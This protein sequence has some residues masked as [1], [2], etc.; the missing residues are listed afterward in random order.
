MAEGC[1][2]V[3]L[4]SATQTKDNAQALQKRT[5]KIPKVCENVLKWIYLDGAGHICSGPFNPGKTQ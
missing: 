1:Y 2:P 3:F 5:N 4:Y